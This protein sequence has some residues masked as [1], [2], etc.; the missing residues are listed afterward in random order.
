MRQTERVF[1]TCSHGEMMQKLFRCLDPVDRIFSNNGDIA[2]EHVSDHSAKKA[3][4]LVP[5]FLGISTWQILLTKRAEHLSN[6][7][8]QVSFPGG[9]HEPSDG[10][11]VETALREALEE[12]GLEPSNVSI[13]GGLSPVRSPA[14][15]FVQPIVGLVVVQNSLNSFTPDPSEVDTIFTLPLAHII[16]QD[17][18]SLIQRKTDGKRNDYWVVKH[19]VHHIW[20]LSARVLWD[21]QKRLDN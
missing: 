19:D 5:I 14:G 4:I 13:A 16:N 12:V 1:T 17:N 21:F 20:G 15:F 3:A 9:K 11:L 8:G 18:F 7:A 6:H 10:N 2:N